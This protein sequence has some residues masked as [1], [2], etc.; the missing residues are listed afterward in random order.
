[1]SCRRQEMLIQGPLPDPKCKSI[2]SLFFILSHLLDCLIWTRNAMFIVLL[3]QMMGDRIVELW[4]IYDRVW[5]GCRECIS[6]ESSCFFV[7]LYI[8]LS[9]SQSLY[10]VDKNMMAVASVSLFCFYFLCLWSL[11]LRVTSTQKFLCLL[12]KTILKVR[13][14]IIILWVSMEKGECFDFIHSLK[15]I[16]PTQ[17]IIRLINCI[18]DRSAPQIVSLK[19]EYTFCF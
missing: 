16:Y 8:V 2:I 14:L 6:S 7:I 13:Y 11:S 17:C 12:C 15:C 10:L 5:A 18:F 4:F 19:K 9:C 1:M 3:L